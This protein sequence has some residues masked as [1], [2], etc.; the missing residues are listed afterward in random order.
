RFQKVARS[1]RLLLTA[2]RLYRAA[3]FFIRGLDR[4]VRQNARLLMGEALLFPTP[5]ER[6]RALED[7]SSVDARLW[8]ARSQVDGLFVAELERAG[9]AG[10]VE[11]A[12]ARLRG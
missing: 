6:R 10:R 7:F 4:I 11:L 3:T 2:I 8:D 1:L 5:V 12:A 9:D